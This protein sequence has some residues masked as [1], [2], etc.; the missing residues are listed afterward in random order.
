MRYS[1]AP[2]H[3]PDRA[4][5]HTG[6]QDRA[7]ETSVNTLTW[8]D[9]RGRG[10]LKGAGGQFQVERVMHDEWI[11]TGETGGILQGVLGLGELLL[12]RS[13]RGAGARGDFLI[14]VASI[15]NT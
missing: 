14:T 6:Q 1:R 8:T 10:A 11:K 9:G 13:L 3:S 5:N 4:Q 2:Q 15:H 7:G 12:S